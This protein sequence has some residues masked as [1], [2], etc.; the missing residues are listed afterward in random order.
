MAQ[1]RR[2]IVNSYGQ[3]PGKLPKPTLAPARPGGLTMPAPSGAS[4]P[5]GFDPYSSPVYQQGVAGAQRRYDF[6][7]AGFEESRNQLNRDYGYRP[8]MV[9][10]K[11]T[12]GFELDP[13][14]PYSKAQALQRAYDNHQRGATNSYAAQGQ[15]YSGALQNS[16]NEGQRGFQEGSYH[17]GNEY[18]DQ[19]LALARRKQA[20]GIDKDDADLAALTAAFMGRL[21]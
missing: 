6:D 10:G 21:G 14:N 11:P 9:A 5:S 15:L 17:L 1:L 7:V 20:A 8:V 12:S 2:R 18:A 16:L 19:I 3:A 4:A 13:T